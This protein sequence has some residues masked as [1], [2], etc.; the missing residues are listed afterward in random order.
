MERHQQRERVRIA[1]AQPAEER[2]PVASKAVSER[3]AVELAAERVPVV[4]RVPVAELAATVERRQGLAM[5]GAQLAERAAQ[6]AHTAEP[7][8]RERVRI[9]VAVQAVRPRLGPELAA[10]GTAEQ[11]VHGMQREHRHQYRQFRQLARSRS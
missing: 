8:Q 11:R 3:L 10:E 4:E 2:E 6:A 9:A 1:V 7:V 5:Q